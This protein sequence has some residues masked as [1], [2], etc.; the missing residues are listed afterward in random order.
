MTINFEYDPAEPE[1]NQEV[2]DQ[3]KN[4]FGIN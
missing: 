4:I 1:N 2:L 3:L